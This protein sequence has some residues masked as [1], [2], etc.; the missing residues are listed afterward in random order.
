MIDS[1]QLIEIAGISR[2]TLNNYVALGILPPPHISAPLASSDRATR[3]G[4]FPDEALDRIREVQL[5]KKQG[6]SMVEI[7]RQCGKE[8]TVLSAAELPAR[9][10]NFQSGQPSKNATLELS[11]DNFPGPAYM[12]DNN[13]ELI[14]WNDSAFKEIFGNAD[15][16]EGESRNLLKLLL[17]SVADNEFRNEYVADILKPHLAA[18]KNRLDQTAISKL[19]HSIDGIHLPLCI[20]CPIPITDSGLIRSPILEV[21]DHLFWFYPITFPGFPE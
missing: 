4:F 15:L 2:A 16:A 20:F 10:E 13:F 21:F 3:L 5:L 1:K 18:A 12:V 9:I 14:W 19:F 11:V 6:L 7:S 17:A 8:R